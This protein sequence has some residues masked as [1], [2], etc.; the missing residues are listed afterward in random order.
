M[1]EPTA[2]PLRRE[3]KYLVP[4]S[5]IPA[6]RASL[7]GL[8]TLD[9]HAGPDG[10]YGL[11]SLYL[12]SPELRLYHANEREAPVRFKARLRTYHDAPGAPVV[13][14]IK[15]RHGDVIRKTRARLPAVGWTEVFA[16]GG[17]SGEAEPSLNEF[18]S[19]VHR[20]RLVPQVLVEYRREAYESR[21]D[22][23]ARISIDTQI[24]CQREAQLD[25]RGSRSWRPIDH[26]LLTWTDRSTCVVELKWAEVAPRWMI[27]LVHRLDL[28]RHSFS[29]YCFSMLSLAEDHARDYREAQSVWG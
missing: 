25:L 3:F 29:K 17:L 21:W 23:Y 26:P 10:T 20:Y 19:R 14:E 5:A 6:L 7:D 16:P 8:C 1:I 22:E 15:A 12:D 18:M 24:R 28:M 2:I 9:A 4:R 27:D 11:R 13:A